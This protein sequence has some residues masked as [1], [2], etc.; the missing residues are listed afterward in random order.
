MESIIPRVLTLN[1]FLLA[2][3]IVLKGLSTLRVFEKFFF[4]LGHADLLSRCS[5]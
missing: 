3:D 1:L 4:Q 5:N 2:E